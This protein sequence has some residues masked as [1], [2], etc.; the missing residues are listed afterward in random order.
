[1][2]SII[3][4]TPAQS[5]CWLPYVG[6]LTNEDHG[7]C[8]RAISNALLYLKKRWPYWNRA[9][10]ILR[11][12]PTPGL[13]TMGVTDKA[14][15]VY[16]PAR[17]LEDAPGVTWTVAETAAVI[18][19]EYLH[20]FLEHAKRARRLGVNGATAQTWNLAA[21]YEINHLLEEGAAGLPGGCV[22]AH[23]Q[24]FDA[25]KLA[26]FYYHQLMKKAADEPDP[27]Q[28]EPDPSQGESDTGDDQDGDDQDGGS[29]DGDAGDDETD[30]TGDG[31]SGDGE[32]QDSEGQDGG[33]GDGG[34]P[35]EAQR[36]NVPGTP[37]ASCGSGADGQPMDPKIEEMIKDALGDAGDRDDLDIEIDAA[38]R[39]AAEAIK[40][41]VET[42]AK[43]RS[44]AYTK[45]VPFIGDHVPGSVKRWG[46]EMAAAIAEGAQAAPVPWHVH[47]SRAAR[48]AAPVLRKGTRD[49]TMTRIARRQA[50]LGYTSG[51]RL[52]AGIDATPNVTIA[53][54]TSGSVSDDMI[55]AM[56]EEI[57]KL[58]RSLDLQRVRII[59]CDTAIRGDAHV[60][61]PRFAR[62]YVSGG[63]GT[64]FD[65]V[66]E[67][68]RKTG[69]RPDVLIYFTDG[70]GYVYADDPG[71]PVVWAL[72][73]TYKQE[74]SFYNDARRPFGK[75]VEI[76]ML[77]DL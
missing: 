25:G 76:E 42:E 70:C 72:W 23:Q 71:Y 61:N 62:D 13:C 15:V 27:G 16:D 69:P 17:V 64:R 19:H 51:P 11:F 38:R 5:D 67:H 56:L 52:A 63:G 45:K 18:V 14:V 73:G 54:D 39:K 12:V 46:D 3:K 37:G 10:D 33:S 21:D 22:Y 48:N 30:E 43:E 66:F 49:Y 36:P 31:G 32:S 7:K 55:T 57:A 35:E 40:D 24:G 1:M 4:N 53:I 2:K 50:S 41:A 58:H 29:G 77:C 9:T 74:P 65:P 26:E 75:M 6:P 8:L 59:S 60:T 34:L 44:R 28:G 47:V 20:C 68:I